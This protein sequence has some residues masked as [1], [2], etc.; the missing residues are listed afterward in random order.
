MRF[1]A[2]CDRCPERSDVGQQRGPGRTRDPLGRLR[3]S[4]VC[5][6]RPAGL[7]ATLDE[8][9]GRPAAQRSPATSRRAGRATT[10]RCPTT[11]GHPATSRRAGRATTRRRATT[12]GC[13]TSCRQV[14]TGRRTG[15]VA[16]ALGGRL[17]TLASLGRRSIASAGFCRTRRSAERHRFR[18]LEAG[19]ARLGLRR[20]ESLRRGGPLR[21][22]GTQLTG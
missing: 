20:C 9:R 14:T 17:A 11:S 18:R 1:A 2:S 4:D 22:Q 5:F 21:G 7:L 8:C 3:C 6:A 19:C 12:S 10:R 13:P 15:R 16:V